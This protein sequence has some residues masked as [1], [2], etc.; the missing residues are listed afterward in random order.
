VRTDHT[1]T[2]ALLARTAIF[3]LCSAPELA[4]LAATAYPM[5]FEPG[6]VL[7][8]EGAESSECY[9]IAEGEAHV[10]IGGRSVR[11]VGEG[12]V[13]GE[14]APLEGRPR[15]ATVTA[16]THMLTWAISRERFLAVIGCNPALAERMRQEVARRYRS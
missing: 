6:N 1:E 8:S 12:D 7:C 13:V 10:T 16:V 11:T 15:S 4:E 9:A 2:A 3:R 14:R 5:S